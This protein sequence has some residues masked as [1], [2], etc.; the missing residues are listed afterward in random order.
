MRCLRPAFLAKRSQLRAWWETTS[1][2]ICSYSHVSLLVAPSFMFD[3]VQQCFHC[4]CSVSPQTSWEMTVQRLGFILEGQYG[5]EWDTW[6]SIS[7][8]SPS[9]WEI[10]RRVQWLWLSLNEPREWVRG[11]RKMTFLYVGSGYASPSNTQSA[12][13]SHVSKT[14]STLSRLLGGLQR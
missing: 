14:R 8:S 7:I 4:Y 6:K 12:S 11:L 2:G 3:K 9:R 1:W 13:V 10:K 5:H